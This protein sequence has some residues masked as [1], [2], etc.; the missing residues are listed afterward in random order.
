MTDRKLPAGKFATPR[1][2][3]EWADAAI[4]TYLEACNAEDEQQ[5]SQCLVMLL[6]TAVKRLAIE[7]GTERTL[8]VLQHSMTKI[9]EAAE[10]GMAMLNANAGAGSTL[11]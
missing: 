7:A 3:A 1:E 5:K 6:S 10:G 2:A 9:I 8:G 11:Q 4:H